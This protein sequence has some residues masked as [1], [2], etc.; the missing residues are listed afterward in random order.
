MVHVHGP[1]SDPM[2]GV[3]NGTISSFRQGMGE[4]AVKTVKILLKKCQM[5]GEDPYA[6]LLNYRSTPI[7]NG[8]SP[9]ELVMGRKLR[10]KVPILSS[11]LDPGI[12]DHGA[13]S[14]KERVY[15]SKCKSY[16]YKRSG[17]KSF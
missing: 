15:K 14:E 12:V 3:R 10:T 13:A 7:K 8:Y 16:Y 9:A 4:S 1:T 11:E 2:H 5:S 17:E 6:A